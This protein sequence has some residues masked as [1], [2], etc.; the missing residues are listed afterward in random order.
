MNAPQPQR[1]LARRAA[2]AVLTVAA[3]AVLG[4]YLWGQRAHIAEHFA[5]DPGAMTAIAALMVLALGLRG[6]ANR[7]LFGRLGVD[8]PLG[9]WFAVVCVNA[10]TNYL[11]LSAGIFAKAFYLKRV[12]A[13]GYADF[14]VGQTALLLVF[15]ATNGAVGCAA[16]LTLGAGSGWLAAA[17]GAMALAGSVVF[18]PLAWTRRLA[19]RVERFFPWNE[20]T[21]TAIRRA[22][23]VVAPLQVAVLL[24]NAAGLKLG[25]AM[26]AAPVGFAACLIFSAATVVTRIVTIS[27]GALGVREFLIGGLAVATGFELSDAVVAASVARL[28][29]MLAIFALGGLF[30]YRLS[31]RV[32]AS[33]DETRPG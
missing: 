20:S 16:A 12:H 22:A 26:G 17:L 28:A 32:A 24:A 4:G 7:A 2:P 23:P 9:D 13:L 19:R 5:F 18:W 29:E 14:A 8:A 31:D 3:L 11:P 1:S 21:A 6:A 25:F 15:I 33:Y 30:T 10:F 27:P